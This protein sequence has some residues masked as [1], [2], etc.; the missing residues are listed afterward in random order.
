MIPPVNIPSVE[1][2]VDGVRK[3]LF[4]SNE[5]PIDKIM[6]SFTPKETIR[7]AYIPTIIGNVCIKYAKALA[8]YCA[9]HQLPYKKEVREIRT[10]CKDYYAGAIYMVTASTLK[11]L[12]EQTD[13]FFSEA[14]SD[15][16]TLYWVI[17]QEIMKN[18][19]NTDYD[20]PTYAYMY[21]CLFAYIQKFQ[22]TTDAEIKKRTHTSF[23]FP[24]D[25]H[26]ASIKA[27]MEKITSN[28]RIDR[29]EMIERACKV[30][31]NRIDQLIFSE[32]H[33]TND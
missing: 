15:V 16:N 28:S 9:S 5:F 25:P 1:K 22:A 27:N 31:A 6:K 30:I 29:T 4:G 14:G 23:Y 21:F 33:I 26:L 2:V 18:Y 19:P 12:E 11:K 13:Y 32:V 17:R 3:E 7:I 8:D 10:S 24:M 20:L